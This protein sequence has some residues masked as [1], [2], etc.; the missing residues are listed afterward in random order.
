MSLGDVKITLKTGATERVY[1]MR[2]TW[3]A[4]WAIED[5]LGGLSVAGLLTSP[6]MSR[7][8]TG[9]LLTTVIT[10]GIKADGVELTTDDVAEMI[11]RTGLGSSGVI[12]P[13]IDFLGM[14][15]TGGV[16]A[17]SVLRDP[18]L[19]TEGDKTVAHLGGN[20]SES[21]SSSSDGPSESSGPPPSQ[22]H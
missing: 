1:T 20:G 22:E 7:Q 3:G 14:L 17:D 18:T 12:N 13:A 19:T 9:R 15:V 6:V 2:P 5:Q 21:P 4:L 10:E 16:P 11:F 8:L